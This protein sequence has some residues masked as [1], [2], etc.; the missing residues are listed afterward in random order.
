MELWRNLGT[1]HST[2]DLGTW[3]HALLHRAHGA[4][5]VAPAPLALYTRLLE[6]TIREFH[7]FCQWRCLLPKG[8]VNYF[9]I[10]AFHCSHMMEHADL[11]MPTLYGRSSGGPFIVPSPRPPAVSAAAIRPAVVR[12]DALSLCLLYKLS[13]ATRVWSAL[14]PV[15][16]AVN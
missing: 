5:G 15:S 11:P 10:M 4:H 8:V 12:I 9:T 2:E 3:I 6:S 7:V 14:V 1:S 13:L 16:Q